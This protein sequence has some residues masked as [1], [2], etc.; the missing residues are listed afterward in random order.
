MKRVHI[1]KSFTC[2]VCDRVFNDKFYMSAHMKRRHTANYCRFCDTVLKD[3]SYTDFKAHYEEERR[4][5]AEKNAEK[6]KLVCDICGYTTIQLGKLNVHLKTHQPEKKDQPTPCDV[7]NKIFKHPYGMRKHRELMHSE[8]TVACEQCEA[9][10]VTQVR[11]N[12]HITAVHRRVSCEIC[13]ESIKQLNLKAHIDSKHRNIQPFK[14][15]ICGTCFNTRKQG[16]RHLMTHS[17]VS[18]FNCHI[19]EKGYYDQRLLKKHYASA[20]DTH[21]ELKEVLTVCV[22]KKSDVDESNIIEV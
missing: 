10:F 16:V 13:G 14:C 9:K 4:K 15:N 22:R 7:C 20:H 2:T 19:C 18:A 21:L 12:Q 1:S 5:R 11:L 6:Q 8:K 3:L 17:S